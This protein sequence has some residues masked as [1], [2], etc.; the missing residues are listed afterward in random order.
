MTERPCAVSAFD[1]DKGL[2][3]LLRCLSRY[4]RIR[5]A[6]ESV[7]R[8][9]GAGKKERFRQIFAQPLSEAVGGF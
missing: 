1:R 4:R 3:H 2:Y 6:T 7:E 8:E 9:Q 5:L